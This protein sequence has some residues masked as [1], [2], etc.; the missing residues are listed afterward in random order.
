M[1]DLHAIDRTARSLTNEKGGFPAQEQ[2][3]PGLTS[4]MDPH[5]DH[6]EET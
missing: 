3:P 2:E 4:K 6:G 1:P 5:P